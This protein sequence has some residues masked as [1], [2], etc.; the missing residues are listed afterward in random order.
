MKP[1]LTY[2]NWK[3]RYPILLKD[4]KKEGHTVHTPWM[5][6]EEICSDLPKRTLKD[7]SFASL[8]IQPLITL[9]LKYK[10][11]GKRLLFIGECEFDKAVAKQL[12]IRYINVND[13]AEDYFNGSRKVKKVLTKK[14]KKI[15]ENK[16]HVFTNPQYDEP[17]PNAPGQTIKVW[18]KRYQFALSLTGKGKYFLPVVPYSWLESNDAKLLKTRTLTLQHDLEKVKINVQSMFPGKPGVGIGYSRIKKG[19]P[20]KGQTIYCD[21]EDNSINQTIDLHNGLPKTSEEQYV[22]NLIEKIINSSQK[23]YNWI[24]GA[25]PSKELDKHQPQLKLI[26]NYSKAYYHL[27]DDD[28]G[29]PITTEA[30]N[31]KQVLLPIKSEQEGLEHKSW[32][33]STPIVWLANNYKRRGQTGFY[34]AVLRQ[35]IPQ[36][37]TKMWTDNEAYKVLGLTQE[38]INY[39]E[40]ADVKANKRSYK[41]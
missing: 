37:Q 8:F 33:H 23:K 41:K 22:L 14:V 19:T 12:K 29:M 20:Y 11:P 40:E 38:E 27:T 7:D 24:Y 6:V 15:M 30:I 9:K 28:H 21:Y 18:P 26:I 13:I 10:I 4:E 17:N 31:S 25:K 3:Q 34:D 32:L 36:F 16:F 39:I 1:N 5:L 35:I 2:N